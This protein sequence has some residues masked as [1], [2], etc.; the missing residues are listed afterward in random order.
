MYNN[1]YHGL[2]C[3]EKWD[4]PM[5]GTSKIRPP[6]VGGHVFT[7]FDSSRALCFGGRTEQGRT[8]VTWIFDLDKKVV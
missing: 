7:K 3:I 8:D 5:S 4:A 6:P 2:N 1:Y